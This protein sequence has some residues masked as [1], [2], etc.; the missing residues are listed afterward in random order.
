MVAMLKILVSFMNQILKELYV[1]NQ[2]Y[3]G[4]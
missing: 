4:K 2:D 1:I 3:Y